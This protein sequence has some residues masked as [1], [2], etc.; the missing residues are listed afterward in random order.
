VSHQAVAWALNVQG[1]QSSK[2]FVLIAL[3]NYASDTGLSYPSVNTICH[4]TCQKDDT[5]RAALKELVEIGVI[6]DTGKLTGATKQIKVYQLPEDAYSPPKTGVFEDPRKRGGK[7]CLRSGKGPGKTP[8]NGEPPNIGNKEQGK[9]PGPE[10]PAVSE[11]EKLG[12][13]EFT[14]AWVAEF[15]KK[16]RTPYLFRSSIDGP[17]AAR[18]LKLG[19]E[20]CDLITLAKRA[21]AVKSFHCDK[22]ASIAGFAA[23]FNDISAELNG[24]KA[25][26]QSAQRPPGMGYGNY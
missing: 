2:K 13:R 3:A 17:A 7:N 12:M 20:P 19:L 25:T 10:V 24:L 5:V 15:K 14:D 6:T 1:L 26:S 4:L 11:S 8:E 23:N 16:F 9:G 22:A 18:L 21:W